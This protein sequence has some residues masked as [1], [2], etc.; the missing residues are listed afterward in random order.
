MNQEWVA[1]F[2]LFL[3]RF[4]AWTQYLFLPKIIVLV[5]L[6]EDSHVPETVFLVYLLQLCHSQE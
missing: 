6:L 2:L 3:L 4:T 5:I 1:Y